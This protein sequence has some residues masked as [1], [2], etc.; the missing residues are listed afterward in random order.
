MSGVKIVQF[1]VYIPIL[2]EIRPM[3]RFLRPKMHISEIRVSGVHT[4]VKHVILGIGNNFRQ[5]R[6]NDSEV[7]HKKTT[8][9]CHTV[10]GVKIVQFH[11]GIP[12]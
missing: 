4:P 7:M 11:V 6:W 12:I 3:D 2:D 9:A 10:S 8:R 1:H 5:N